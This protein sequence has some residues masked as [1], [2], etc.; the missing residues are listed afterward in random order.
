MDET[1][2]TPEYATTNV[3]TTTS[4]SSNNCF[5]SVND[6][7]S[8]EAIR[9]FTLQH[10]NDKR[11]LQDLNE[12]FTDYLRRL[13]G[14]EEEN[15][16]LQSILDDRKK[17]SGFDSAYIKDQYDADLQTLRKQVDDLAHDKSRAELG[18]KRDELDALALK[19]RINFL[20]RLIMLDNDRLVKLRQKLEESQAELQS[21]DQRVND[22]T[23]DLDRSRNVLEDLYKTLDD[24]KDRFDREALARVIAQN[25]LQ[26]IEED[27]AFRRAINEEERNELSSLGALPFDN[28]QF[29]RVELSRAINLIKSDFEQLARQRRQGFDE[30][31]EY[32]NNEFRRQVQIW[33]EQNRQPKAAAMAPTSDFAALQENLRDQKVQN[34][35]IQTNNADLAS[36]LQQLQTQYNNLVRDKERADENRTQEYAQMCS[37]TQALE[38]ALA[39]IIDNNISLQSDINVYRRLLDIQPE[40]SE[41]S[42]RALSPPL[43]ALP[44]QLIT[45]ARTITE[46]KSSQGPVTIDQADPNGD[47]IL[48][49][50][51]GSTNQPLSGWTI[52]RTID[53]EPDIVFQFPDDL[54]L[55]AGLRLRVLS[56]QGRET[57]GNLRDAILANAIATWGVGD[58]IE[59]RLFD[60]NNVSKAYYKQ[61][62]L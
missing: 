61:S 14:L 31:Y 48:L 42:Q 13:K 32:K 28:Q 3:K 33:E 58:V 7:V 44:E 36:E 11:D 9:N 35:Q 41:S 43:Q 49:E 38:R 51:K 34:Q 52:R 23:Q 29:Y 4:S 8:T 45:E 16:R 54:V 27:I 15:R 30:L 39:D 62:C 40:L 18:A 5:C 47:F 1:Y 2:L 26:T 25:E 20:N 10:N 59:T 22:R 55:A 46:Q 50:N 37:E 57:T 12:R 21:L 56:R 19:N 24:L 53:T 60:E 6:C 17:Q